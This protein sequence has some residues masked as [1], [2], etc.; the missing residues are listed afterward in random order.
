MSPRYRILAVD[1]HADT[2]VLIRET[3][4]E[5]YDVLTLAN[6]VAIYDCID[7]FEPDLLI[8]DIM[9]PKITGYQLIEI[10]KKNPKTQTLPIII[11]SAKDSAREI[12]YGYQLGASLYLTKPFAPDRLIKNTET[13]F[14]MHPPDPKPKTYTIDQVRIKI[15]VLEGTRTGRMQLSS[16]LLTPENVLPARPESEGRGQKPATRAPRTKPKTDVDPA[17]PSWHG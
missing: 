4:R 2:L 9:M 1:D 3:L 11:L 16:E 13:Q 12:K 6:P 8:L 5:S 14:R 15:E 17:D 7:L 10:L